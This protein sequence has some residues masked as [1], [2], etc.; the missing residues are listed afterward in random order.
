MSWKC[1][2]C[3]LVNEDYWLNCEGCGS[4]DGK[5]LRSKSGNNMEEKE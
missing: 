2:D 1:V 5:H 4:F 3:G